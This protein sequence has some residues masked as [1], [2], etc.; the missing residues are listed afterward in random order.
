M[1]KKENKSSIEKVKK[2]L[3][4]VTLENDKININDFQDNIIANEELKENLELALTQTNITTTEVLPKLASSIVKYI[5]EFKSNLENLTI[6]DDMMKLLLKKELT[7]HCYQLVDY[8]RKDGV[9]DLF[10]KVVS[11]AIRLGIMIVDFP[12]EFSVDE[13]T[14]EVFIMSKVLEPQNKIK[15]KGSKLTKKV[16]N[17]DDSLIPVTTYA[18]DKVYARKYPTGKRKTKTKDEKAIKE[19]KNIT[20]DFLS[21]FK[22]LIAYSSKQNVKF[23]DMVDDNTFENLEEIKM[24]LNSEDYQNIRTFSVEYQVN[25]NG[26]LEKVKKAVNQQ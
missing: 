24:F 2:I 11:R 9:N 7:T 25:F 4:D 19:F 8:K 12:E 3:D 18:V 15:I 10:E 21:G 14:S 20:K 5:N 1:T 6:T 13:E 26:K 16:N 22:K 17:E 23:F